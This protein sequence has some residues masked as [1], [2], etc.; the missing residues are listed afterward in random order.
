MKKLNSNGQV[1]VL[2]VILLPIILILL[3]IIIEVGNIYIE[4]SKTKSIIKETITTGLKE[5]LQSDAV[6]ALIEIN[7]KNIKEKSI[8]TSETEID[9]K[10]TKKEKIFGKNVEI[11]YNIKGIKENENIKIS[12]G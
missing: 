12:E 11:E 1:L 5:N 6:N 2:F 7:I 10:L 8:Y 3:L 4:K 9:V